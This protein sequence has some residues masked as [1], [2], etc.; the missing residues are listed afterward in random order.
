MEYLNFFLAP[1]FTAGFFLLDLGQRHDLYYNWFSPAV[2]K[3]TLFHYLFKFFL[4]SLFFYVAYYYGVKV[5]NREPSDAVR[6]IVKKETP[7]WLIN[8]LTDGIF[9]FFAHGLFTSRTIPGRDTTIEKLIVK[10]TF[11]NFA[12]DL[13]DGS[14]TGRLV[15]ARMHLRRYKRKHGARLDLATLRRKIDSY[16][17]HNRHALQPQ[18]IAELQAVANDMETGMPVETALAYV[19]IN[20]TSAKVKTILAF[21]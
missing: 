11:R 5:F 17:S 16:V 1:A 2:F 3:N 14:N 10:R 15:I 20:F 9:A 6:E 21:S 8:I 4:V 19:L 12:D 18:K 13:A 7:D